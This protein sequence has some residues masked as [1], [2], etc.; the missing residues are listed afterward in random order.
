MIVDA[1]NNPPI[2]HR[3]FL[4]AR[5]DKRSRFATGLSSLC[6]LRNNGSQILGLRSFLL[7]RHLFRR[8][9]LCDSAI[10]ADSLSKNNVVF[11]CVRK[12]DD[13]FSGPIVPSQH[14]F[15]ACAFLSP[16]TATIISFAR[17]IC[18][19]DIET[20]LSGTSERSANHPSLTCCCLH[21]LFS[22]TTEIRFFRLKIRRWIVKGQVTVFSDPCEQHVHRF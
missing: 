18:R 10:A 11:A 15:T 22:S 17:N 4:M 14:N 20:A 19:T 7:K 8:P 3:R 16:G 9:C 21:S 13:G 2:H 1:N 6:G 5:P 12:I